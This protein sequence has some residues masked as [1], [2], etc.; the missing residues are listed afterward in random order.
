MP[1]ALVRFL[2]PDPC[3]RR[4]QWSTGFLLPPRMAPIG[5]IS[6]MAVAARLA[7]SPQVTG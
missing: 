6:P 1:G 7:G 4:H 2:A 5:R 3:Q